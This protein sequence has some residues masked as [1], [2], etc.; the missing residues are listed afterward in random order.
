MGTTNTGCV[1]DKV[2]LS[3]LRK[4]DRIVFRHTP[5]KG[6]AIEAIQANTPSEKD[7]FARD[8]VLS[9]PC[10]FALDDYG[11][12]GTDEY[13][14]QEKAFDW[15]ACNNG[16]FY[17]FDMEHTAKSSKT[18]QSIVSVMK[19]GD[20]IGLRWMRNAGTNPAI[21]KLGVVSDTLELWVE[22]GDKSA[23]RFV[24]ST[25]SVPAANEQTRIV[26]KY[27]Y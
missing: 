11:G 24:V 25:H 4:A 26:S 27:R 17:G 18:W 5:D 23:G 16:T 14:A 6:S 9:V 22:R 20:I 2:M 13:P 10:R 8:A 7:P 3:A 1:I 21:F 15:G 19:A 12:H